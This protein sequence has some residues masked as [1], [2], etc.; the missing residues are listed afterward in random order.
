MRDRFE[1][2]LFRTQQVRRR[3][4]E[5]F[6]SSRN[7]VVLKKSQEAEKQLDELIVQLSREGYN[8]DRFKDNTTQGKLM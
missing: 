6:R 3:Q 1:L 5:Y 2:L 7:K 4:N 8:G